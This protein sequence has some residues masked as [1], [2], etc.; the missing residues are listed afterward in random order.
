[1]IGIDYSAN[2]T[3]TGCLFVCFRTRVDEKYNR[4]WETLNSVFDLPR[5]VSVYDSSIYHFI[6]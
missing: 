6:S 5:T 1:M 3:L 2:G 4:V